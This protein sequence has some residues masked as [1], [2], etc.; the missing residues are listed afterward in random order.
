MVCMVNLFVIGCFGNECHTA[1]RENGQTKQSETSE[2]HLEYCHS[3][4]SLLG[5]G[6][7]GES[8]NYELQIHNRY[9]T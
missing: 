7:G 3:G 9:G 5:G 1:E 2:I 4:C 6:G 8:H